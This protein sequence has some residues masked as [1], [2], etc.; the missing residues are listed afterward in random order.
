[1]RSWFECFSIRDT[2]RSG[3]SGRECARIGRL[4]RESL[5]RAERKNV[6]TASHSVARHGRA[7]STHCER[8]PSLNCLCESSS[9]LPYR[10]PRTSFPLY[11]LI[12]VGGPGVGGC[13]FRA[14]PLSWQ[15][16]RG[17]RCLREDSVRVPSLIRHSRFT[18]NQPSAQAGV[19]PCSAGPLGRASQNT[20]L[21][22]R[23][24]RAGKVLPSLLPLLRKSSPKQHEPRAS[25]TEYRTE[26]Q[27]IG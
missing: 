20:T 3:P 2:R 10:I 25:N 17:G 24:N 16:T 21:S 22:R 7:G 4:I 15:N 1:M 26:I 18:V 8:I 19:V 6:L 27:G 23:E 12:R 9:S 14:K 5:P 13:V 11:L